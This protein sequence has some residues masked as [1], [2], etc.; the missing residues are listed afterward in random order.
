VSANEA[1]LSLTYF[2]PERLSLTPSA[3]PYIAYR[4]SAAFVLSLTISEGQ[5]PLNQTE[6]MEDF[7][8]KFRKIVPPETAETIAS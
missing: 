4:S 8:V 7:Q 2:R 3:F 5:R 1:T 6:S